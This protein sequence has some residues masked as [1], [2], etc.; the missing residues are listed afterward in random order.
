M[1]SIIALS[2]V[3]VFTLALALPVWAEVDVN[4]ASLSE[5]QALK[6][7]G[8]KTAE[9]IVA[10]REANGPFTSLSN[11]AARVKGIGPKTIANWE[12]MA[13]CTQPGVGGAQDY[14][15]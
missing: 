6:G 9:K 11:L 14:A 8:P 4:S 7:V 15:E 3:A 5:L 10:E 13:V 2:L 1:R 12:G